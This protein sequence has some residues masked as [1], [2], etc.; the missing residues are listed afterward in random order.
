MSIKIEKAAPGFWRWRCRHC[1]ASGI[2][3]SSRGISRKVGRVHSAQCD[4]RDGER[5]LL[6]R[7]ILGLY[8]RRDLHGEKAIL[9]LLGDLAVFAERQGLD[10]DGILRRFRPVEE[11]DS[12]G[13]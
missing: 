3:R 1:Q 5:F 2:P 8:E 13:I 7:R 10:F 6:A 4:S 9:E 12:E 11:E